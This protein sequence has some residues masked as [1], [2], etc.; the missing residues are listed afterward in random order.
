[1]LAGMLKSFL[2]D[3]FDMDA[4]IKSAQAFMVNC[5]TIAE[6]VQN[7]AASLRRIELMLT[8]QT[9]PY[10]DNSATLPDQQGERN[11]DRSNHDGATDRIGDGATG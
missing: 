7:N 5:A 4:S 3:D 9:V 6:T 8:A 10:S 11:D 2:P 1:M